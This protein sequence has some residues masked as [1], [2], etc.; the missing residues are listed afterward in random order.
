[1]KK[2]KAVSIRINSEVKEQLEIA[3]WSPQV[4]FDWALTQNTRVKTLIE[5]KIKNNAIKNGEKLK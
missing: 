4:L 1:M 2:D 3:G 5:V